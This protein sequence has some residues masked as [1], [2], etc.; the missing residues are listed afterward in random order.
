MPQVFFNTN[1]FKPDS[2]PVYS[3]KLLCDLSLWACREHPDFSR[4]LDRPWLLHRVPNFM[5][6]LRDRFE[7]WHL[8]H[9]TGEGLERGVL[10]DA[11]LYDNRPWHEYRFMRVGD[12]LALHGDPEGFSGR[13]YGT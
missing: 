6:A 13:F 10:V 11:G 4:R 2:F 7:G 5:E 9:V 8:H 3:E 1:T 12:H